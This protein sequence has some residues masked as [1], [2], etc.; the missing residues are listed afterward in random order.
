MPALP[1]IVVARLEALLCDADGNLFPSEEPA[2]VASAEVTNRFLASLGVD[3][4][5]TAEELRLATTGMNFRTTA[6]R[7][8]AEAGHP[9]ADVEPWVAEEKRAVTAHLGATLT[10]HGPT[11]DALTALAAHLRPAAVS[12][13]ALTRLDACFTATGLAGLIPASVRF[14]AED[15]LPVPTSKPDPA[16]YLYACEQLGIAPEAGLAVEDSIPGALSAVRAGCPTVGNLLFVPAAER[17][18]RAAALTDAG[19][20]VVVDSWQQLADLVL[21]VLTRRATGDLL[22]TGGAK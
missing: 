5:F 20:L 7:L 18:E 9:D 4:R 15:S 12:S 16:V 17:A 13:S 22:S 14:S 3:R 21:P 10:P 1:E 19:V 6:S 8:A 11:T 2:F